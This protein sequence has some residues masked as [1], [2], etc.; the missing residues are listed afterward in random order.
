MGATKGSGAVA[1]LPEPSGK[2]RIPVLCPHQ[3]STLGGAAEVTYLMK[4]PGL[5]HDPDLP[6]P[7]QTPHTSPDLPARRRWPGLL[8]W[9]HRSLCFPSFVC[10]SE[11]S[12][13]PQAWPG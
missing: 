2:A 1:L 5:R 13:L 3:P 8:A 12:I 11:L 6:L 4:K 9:D 7:I 10:L